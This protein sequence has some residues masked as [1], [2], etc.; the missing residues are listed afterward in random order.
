MYFNSKK[1]HALLTSANTDWN[2][3]LFF[4]SP[5]A[6]TKLREL[7]LLLRLKEASAALL[8]ESLRDLQE[9]DGARRRQGASPRE[10]LAEF[11][12]SALSPE[13]A[14]DILARRVELIDI[15]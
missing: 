15:V 10:V 5:G 11:Q 3:T 2:L 8:L 12:V 9:E 7:L 6:Y 14:R 13:R 4:P 1:W